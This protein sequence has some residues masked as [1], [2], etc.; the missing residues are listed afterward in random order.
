M[1]DPQEWKRPFTDGR[2]LWLEIGAFG[3]EIP[4]MLKCILGGIPPHS[5]YQPQAVMLLCSMLGITYG[6]SYLPSISLHS[7]PSGIIWKPSDEIS[8]LR[9]KRV[10]ATNA[11]HYYYVTNVPLMLLQKE[12]SMVS[13]KLCSSFNEAL[14]IILFNKLSWKLCLVV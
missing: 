12:D 11:L 13:A 14:G 6:S 8:W 5:I 7:I 2:R 4:S 10:K 3:F 9:S 1:V